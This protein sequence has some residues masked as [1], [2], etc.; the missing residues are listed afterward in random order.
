M[1]DRT[2]EYLLNAME[3][4]AQAK[5]PAKAGYAA[6]RQAVLAFVAGLQLEAEKRD[7]RVRVLEAKEQDANEVFAWLNANAE[8]ELRIRSS[9]SGHVQID[10]W[11]QRYVSYQCA[12]GLQGICSAVRRF[13]ALDKGEASA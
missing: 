11:Y 10:R 12:V 9:Q 3:R 8:H 6:K 7:A 13:I 4:A 1:P 2:F 5:H